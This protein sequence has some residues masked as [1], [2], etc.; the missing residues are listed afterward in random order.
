MYGL[1]KYSIHLYNKFKNPVYNDSANVLLI[2]DNKVMYTEK[3]EII[4]NTYNIEK[5]KTGYILDSYF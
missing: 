2:T 5:Q 3:M 1:W 4:Y